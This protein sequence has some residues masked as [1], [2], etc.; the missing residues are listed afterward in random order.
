MVV[1]LYILVQKE[2]LP[3]PF[4]AEFVAP[5]PPPKP[6]VRRPVTKRVSQSGRMSGR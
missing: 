6:S 5:P 2:I 4:A 1:T 3:N